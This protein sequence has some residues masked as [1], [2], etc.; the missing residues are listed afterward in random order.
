MK[1]RSAATALL[2][3]AG[4]M[5]SGHHVS[6]EEETGY[7]AIVENY[8][9]G[10]SVKRLIVTLGKETGE[11]SLAP[12]D[13]QVSVRKTYAGTDKPVQ[14]MDYANG[15]YID[16]PEGAGT[17]KVEDVYYCD[18]NGT[19]TETP[20]GHVAIELEV[21]P[22]EGFGSVLGIETETGLRMNTTLDCHYTVTFS[23]QDQKE[24]VCD[25]Q[26]AVKNEL[27]DQFTH[28]QVYT[29][30]TEELLKDEYENETLYYASYEPKDGEKHPLI[31]WL[32][33]I[34]EG[35]TDTRASVTANRV[36]ALVDKEIQG[37][38]GGAYVLAPQCPTFWMNT[39]GNADA[40]NIWLREKNVRSIYTDTLMELIVSY[41][42]SHPQI[43]TDRIYLGGCSNGGYM[44]I[45]MLLHAPDYFAA[46]FPICE[47]YD[48]AL[49]SDEQIKLLAATPIWFTAAKNDAVVNPEKFSVPTYERLLAAGAEN[50]HF[51]YW[52]DVHDVTG[53]FADENG[54]PV[55]YIGHSSWVYVLNNVCTLD[56]D[57]PQNGTTEEPGSGETIFAWLSAQRKNGTN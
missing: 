4:M 51:T 44:T 46:A 39:D 10:A 34:G 37:L 19:R 47:A 14:K 22:A 23:A 26:L 49:L 43:D 48:D 2:L 54:Q 36:T 56:K 50:A 20:G 38:M 12:E 31:I 21:T 57:Y 15:V 24:I 53:E 11:L 27:A 35:G 3:A 32:H 6:A 41:V 13:V 30:R 17:R 45:N 5:V 8:D 29:S 25:T 52:N 7:T 1:K 55:Q 42:E 28:D 9:W 18:E 16:A 40:A 33:G